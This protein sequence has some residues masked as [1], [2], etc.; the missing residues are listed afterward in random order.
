[1][2]VCVCVCARARACVCVCVRVC[3]CVCVRVCVR[4]CVRVCVCVYV[5]A[6]AYTNVCVCIC[7]HI[8]TH[9]QACDDSSLG[10]TE[11]RGHTTRVEKGI[12]CSMTH[13]LDWGDM[14]QDQGV[15]LHGENCV[16]K[17]GGFACTHSVCTHSVCDVAEEGGVFSSETTAGVSSRWWEE[18][19]KRA[20][21]SMESSRQLFRSCLSYPSHPADSHQP[22]PF[23]PSLVDRCTPLDSPRT[24]ADRFSGVLTSCVGTASR[25][26]QLPHNTLT[27][28]HCNTLQHASLEEMSLSTLTVTHCNTLQRALRLDHVPLLLSSS[29]TS[30]VSAVRR[31]EEGREEGGE[32]GGSGVTR[33]RHR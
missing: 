6:Y 31:E 12:L 25:L 15:Y 20:S 24:R 13:K 11:L 10:F 28:T 22:T 23:S 17:D 7:K 16:E 3:V 32:E 8:H 27:A 5:Y 33:M 26:E 30:A 1:M 4:A 19:G 29:G 14:H 18:E 2:C 21:E 9:A